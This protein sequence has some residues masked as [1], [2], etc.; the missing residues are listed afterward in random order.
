MNQIIQNALQPFEKITLFEIS[1]FLIP[2]VIAIFVDIFAHRKHKPITFKNAIIW[3]IVWV[4]CALLYSLV[5]WS[6]RGSDA[7]ASY[8]AAY[9][10]EKALAVDNLFCFFLIFKSFGLLSE[11]NQYLQRVVLSWGIFGSIFFR[12]ILLGFGAF[13][14]N[15][16]H[17]VLLGFGLI[18]LWTVWGMWKASEA[19]IEEVDY[20]KHWSAKLVG[21]FFK[22]NPSIESGKFFHNGATP[23]F[24]CVAVVEFID[25]LFSFD[26]L[27]AVLAITSDYLIVITACLW[28][29]AGLRSLYFLLVAAQDKLWALEKAIMVLL[30]FIG[31]KLIAGGLGFHIPSLL[32]LT[33]VL[34]T[35]AS[36]VA[37][38]LL[39]KEPTKA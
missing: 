11:K 9:F 33:I 35:L 5:I 19:E 23:L 20:S 14:V 17:Y 26:S 7:A 18:V 30:V 39:V 1:S 2:F 28:A 24:V 27:P 29:V 37:V 10:C 4:V 21:K 13:I 25:I 31:G 8:V 38:S 12:V 3:S 6:E 15:A 36:G 32:S 22:V 34:L 16:S